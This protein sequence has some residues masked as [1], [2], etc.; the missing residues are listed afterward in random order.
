MEIKIIGPGCAKCGKLEE[1]VNEVVQENGIEAEVI[2]VTELLEIAQ[3]GVASTPGLA[4]DGEIKISG[5]VP[6]KEEIT[7]LV[8]E[9]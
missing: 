6:T 2:K 4:I 8:K 3:S 1:L 7:A 9:K 5:R